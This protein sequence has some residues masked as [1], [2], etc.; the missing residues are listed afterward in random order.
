MEDIAAKLGAHVS[1]HYPATALCSGEAEAAQICADSIARTTK[2]NPSA[3]FCFQAGYFAR[4]IF[5][6][7]IQMIRESKIDFSRSRFVQM[8]E[9]LD[10]EGGGESCTAFLRKHFFDPAGI[11][12]DQIRLFDVYNKDTDS[13]CR[14]MD[15]YI[16][17]EGP[18][19]LM[20]LGLDMN[21]NIGFNHPGVNWDNHSIVVDIDE[22]EGTQAKPARGITLGMRYLYES[23]QVILQALG[24]K[25]AAGVKKMYSSPPAMRLPGT[26]MQ[27]IR[28]GLVI[29]DEKAAA[30]LDRDLLNKV[31]VSQD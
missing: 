27:L 31:L 12:N 5:G 14:N 23:K 30:L 13:I 18:V 15:E 16:A 24:G 3:L 29:L 28:H 1:F 20:I 17:A 10:L 2:E 26:V 9:W 4:E 19:D 22:D 25:N 21:G 6:R 11:R 7:V 8:N